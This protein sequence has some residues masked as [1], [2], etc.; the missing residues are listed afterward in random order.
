VLAQAPPEKRR[1]DDASLA[2]P[3]DQP[4]SSVSETDT[5]SSHE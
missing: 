1:F 2:E 5:V 4:N 3:T